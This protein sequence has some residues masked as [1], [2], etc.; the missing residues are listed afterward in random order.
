M[1]LRLRV[2]SRLASLVM[3]VALMTGEAARAPAFES[4]RMQEAE[5]LA[6]ADSTAERPPPGAA[7][8]FKTDFSRHTVP[9]QETVSGGPPE[10]WNP[11]SK[12]PAPRPD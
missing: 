8:H 2:M 10:G 7:R 4:A 9:Y 11:C 1:P 3:A 12:P 5:H 6:Q